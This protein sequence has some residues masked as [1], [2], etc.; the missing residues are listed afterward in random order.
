MQKQCKSIVANAN[1]KSNKTIKQTKNTRQANKTKQSKSIKQAIKHTMRK[2]LHCFKCHCQSIQQQESQ[3]LLPLFLLFCVYF[4]CWS[5]SEDENERKRE[6]ARAKCNCKRVN[7][8]AS[9]RASSQEKWK[10]SREK[11]HTNHKVSL[12]SSIFVHLN[13]FLVNF[14]SFVFAFALWYKLSLGFS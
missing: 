1:A 7:L 6:H 3:P 10:F 4:C 2:P 9:A 8:F 14:F 12:N 13:Y 5:E 11:N